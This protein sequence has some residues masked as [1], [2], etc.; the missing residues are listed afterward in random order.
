MTKTNP[1]VKKADGTAGNHTHTHWNNQL[2]WPQWQRGNKAGNIG[3]EKT[4][5]KGSVIRNIESI[6]CNLNF[7]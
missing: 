4:R 1:R 3:V 6:C 7:M 2:S 5:N